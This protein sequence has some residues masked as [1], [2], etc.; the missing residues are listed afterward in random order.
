MPF[1][2]SLDGGK[3][4]FISPTRWHCK[5]VNIVHCIDADVCHVIFV[6]DFSRPRLNVTTTCD[7]RMPMF[8]L[9]IIIQENSSIRRIFFSRRLRFTHRTPHAL[10]GSSRLDAFHRLRRNARNLFTS[11]LTLI[12]NELVS[13]GIKY[14]L[15]QNTT[16][17]NA[18]ARARLFRSYPCNCSEQ[19]KQETDTSRAL[20]SPLSVRPISSPRQHRGDD[21]RC[22]GK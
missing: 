1:F 4:N 16:F 22:D 8:C 9:K 13:S 7:H 17:A 14:K 15:A 6:T 3:A 5:G 21:Y 18:S 10:V 19:E 12:D 20:E 2:F 11:S